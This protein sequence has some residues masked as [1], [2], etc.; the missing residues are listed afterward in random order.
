MSVIGNLVSKV[1]WPSLRLGVSRSALATSFLPER[2]AWGGLR[3]QSCSACSDSGPGSPGAGRLPFLAY[4]SPSSSFSLAHT[5][6]T[7]SL[8]RSRLCRASSTSPTCRRP[9]ASTSALSGTPAPLLA[10]GCPLSQAPPSYVSPSCGLSLAIHS[11]PASPFAIRP[12]PALPCRACP[13]PFPSHPT[14]SRSPP[15][16]S[17]HLLLL[18][19]LLLRSPLQFIWPALSDN[20][21]KEVLGMPRPNESPK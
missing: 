8:R 10:S 17:P 18:L 14:D 5:C 16:L 1:R 6:S 2:V 19:L 15:L 20:Y 4:D 11:T 9:L 13:A 21:R 3:V 12:R 7:S